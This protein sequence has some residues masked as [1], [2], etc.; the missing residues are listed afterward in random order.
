MNF[1]CDNCGKI[2]KFGFGNI[3]LVCQ[4]CGCFDIRFDIPVVATP[5]LFDNEGP[6]LTV[7]TNES[8][9]SLHKHGSIWKVSEVPF[10]MKKKEPEPTN[11]EPED[12]AEVDSPIVVV[13]G[14]SEKKDDEIKQEPKVEE[15]PA[16]LKPKKRQPRWLKSGKE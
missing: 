3:N 15:K 14:D 6:S 4:G 7:K 8:F 2:T 16:L 9:Y 13:S 10:E 11:P 5:L 1:K 12:T